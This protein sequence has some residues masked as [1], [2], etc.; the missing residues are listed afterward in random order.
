MTSSEQ[1]VPSGEVSSRP[2]QASTPSP[3]GTPSGGRSLPERA[4]SEGPCPTCGHHGPRIVMCH[5]AYC[6]H[7]EGFHSLRKNGSRGACSWH[8][9]R[10]AVACPCKSFEPNPETS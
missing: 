4:T 6:L 2:G 3:A 8:S 1:P 9:G 10:E 5:N 7:D